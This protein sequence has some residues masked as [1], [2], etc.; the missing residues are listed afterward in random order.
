[1]GEA[2]FKSKSRLWP[3][4]EAQSRFGNIRRYHIFYENKQGLGRCYNTF[5]TKEFQEWVVVF[6]HDD[7]EIYNI[8][9]AYKLNSACS[10]FDIVG[11][12]GSS[13]HNPI[14]SPVTWWGG[15]LKKRSAVRFGQV[16][17]EHSYPIEINGRKLCAELTTMN[18]FGP[19]NVPVKVIDGVFIAVN[20][21]NCVRYHHLFD[22]QF[23]FHFYDLDFSYS[24]H[25][26]GMLVG[27]WD[28]FVK[29]YSH[30][31][32]HSSRWRH[33]ERKYIEKWRHLQELST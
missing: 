21:E 33:N 24:A 32:Y 17:H 28:I 4:L 29:H 25:K 19:C 23:D 12:A 27:V 22:E 8:D 26:K 15:D 11:L 14:Q 20:V 16:A 9:L 6:V 7:I 13:E 31:D 1:L 2:E 10:R 5:L 30:G 18:A 3:Y